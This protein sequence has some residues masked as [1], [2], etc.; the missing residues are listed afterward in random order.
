MDSHALVWP[1]NRPSDDVVLR[2]IL[3]GLWGL[4]LCALLWVPSL[5][6]TEGFGFADIESPPARYQRLAL[7][8]AGFVA[9]WGALRGTRVWAWLL[10]VV[11]PLL[12]GLGAWEGIAYPRAWWMAWWRPT[13]GCA[14][15]AVP[16]WLL[17]TPRGST[18]PPRPR[19]GPG[20]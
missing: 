13:L 4:A 8:V 1:R 15:V 14:L 2:R 19:R 9:V 18:G 17:L 16:A 20:P 10:V 12:L 6:L 3:A 5:S 11:V 7:G